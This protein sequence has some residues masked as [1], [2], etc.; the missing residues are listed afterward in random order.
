MI[1]KICP[2]CDQVMTGFRCK[3]CGSRVRPGQ[4]QK[5]DF[6]LNQRHGQ[7]EESCLFHDGRFAEEPHAQTAMGGGQHSVPG[8][9]A[10][11]ARSV[12]EIGRSRDAA[13]K[14]KLPEQKKKK[15]GGMDAVWTILIWIVFML[16]AMR[17]CGR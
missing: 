15:S 11:R 5:I 16:F 17:G 12:Q 14:Q 2:Y 9:L 13:G 10:E 3:H 4:A 1:Q 7:E 6:Y 8:S